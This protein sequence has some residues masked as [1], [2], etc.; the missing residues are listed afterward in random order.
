LNKEDTNSFSRSRKSEIKA[1]IKIP[2]TTKVEFYQNF[3]KDL[4]RMLLNASELI[5]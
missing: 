5:L 4:A 3:K 1:V 2:P